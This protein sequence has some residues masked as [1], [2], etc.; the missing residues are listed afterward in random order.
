[1]SFKGWDALTISEQSDRI[2]DLEAIN[3]EMLEAL[4]GLVGG[5]RAA[6]RRV[7][8]SGLYNGE[9]SIREGGPVDVALKAIAKAKGDTNAAT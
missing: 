5:V 9:C 2:E 1:M 6:M 8:E 3:A 4:E 7:E